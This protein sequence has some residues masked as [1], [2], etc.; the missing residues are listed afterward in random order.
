[1]YWLD[2]CHNRTSCNTI[3]SQSI[4]FKSR[5]AQLSTSDVHYCKGSCCKPVENTYTTTAKTITTFFSTTCFTFFSMRIESLEYQPKKTEKNKQNSSE[6]D[7]SHMFFGISGRCISIGSFSTV[8]PTSGT[9][10]NQEGVGFDEEHD[11]PQ[12][13]NTMNCK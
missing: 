5:T 6:N 2:N 1:M 3:P 10:S 8:I 9:S 12:E 7:T 13:V 4:C 11:S